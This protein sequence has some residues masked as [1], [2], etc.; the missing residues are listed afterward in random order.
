[1]INVTATVV[2]EGKTREVPVAGIGARRHHQACGGRHDTRRR[3]SAFLQRICSYARPTLTGESLPVEKFD[4][5][6]SKHARASRPWKS[7]RS[8]FS[9]HER[10]E[11]R[12][13]RPWWWKPGLKVTWAPSPKASPRTQSVK[14]SFNKAVKKFTWLMLRFMAVMVPIVFFING[15]TKHD[16]KQGVFAGLVRGGGI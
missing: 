10:G 5:T 9:G 14:T 15:F 7:S 13:R 6:E 8:V 12:R 11:R 2:R 3:A 4:H 1:M 16:W